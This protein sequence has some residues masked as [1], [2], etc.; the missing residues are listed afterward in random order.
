MSAV[1][2][3]KRQ[4]KRVVGQDTN[5][6]QIDLRNLRTSE[7][8]HQQKE[9][10]GGDGD[11][12]G[13]GGADAAVTSSAPSPPRSKPYQRKEDVNL[14]RRVA[15]KLATLG[16]AQGAFRNNLQGLEAK[17][18]TK[19]LPPGRLCESFV[20][21]GFKKEDITRLYNIVAERKRRQ[22]AE[23]GSS[24]EAAG[25]KVVDFL[26]FFEHF[27]P[28]DQPKATVV[29]SFAPWNRPQS[30]RRAPTQ[31]PTHGFEET[32]CAEDLRS[33]TVRAFD[34]HL[35][36][37]VRDLLYHKDNIFRTAFRKMDTNRDGCVSKTEFVSKLKELG[38]NGKQSSR[39][40]DM[41]DEDDS[42]VIDYN[43]FLS[44]FDTFNPIERTAAF[45]ENHAMAASKGSH[46]DMVDSVRSQLGRNDDGN[47]DD[48]H[49]DQKQTTAAY[50]FEMLSGK[51]REREG[52]ILRSLKNRDFDNNGIIPASSA[53]DAIICSVKGLERYRGDVES[54]VNS[55]SSTTGNVKYRD[56][57][58]AFKDADDGS[59]V[60]ERVQER[61]RP[62]T[63]LN[64]MRHIRPYSA[65]TVLS[66]GA[67]FGP[68]RD[69]AAAR[70]RMLQHKAMKPHHHRRQ[71]DSLEAGERRGNG[72]RESQHWFDV[73]YEA[74]RRVGRF[75]STPDPSKRGVFLRG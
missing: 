42:H 30:L 67:A 55:V 44:A 71:Y 10:R 74:D 26:D 50:C 40:A 24:T 22:M 13:F 16:P 18:A 41:V 19:V 68:Q 51:I 33:D 20:R 29:Q 69:N 45:K 28:L 1:D 59:K 11:D 9:S 65:P 7:T 23:D 73:V 70:R 43:E 54:L 57:L 15:E 5:V 12:C 32:V 63:I 72:G 52:T 75:A 4:R 2:P 61:F 34:V 27:T 60:S 56:M 38:L 47:T 49:R 53:V 31:L 64:K 35:M 17:T 58:C 46:P 48:A 66:K 8:H 39:L 6:H 25:V 3:R 21:F 14:I 36:N 62:P 37:I